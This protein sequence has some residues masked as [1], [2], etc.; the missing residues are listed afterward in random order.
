MSHPFRIAV[1]HSINIGVFGDIKEMSRDSFSV[2]NEVLQVG[3]Q[4]ADICIILG[5]M[6]NSTSPTSTSIASTLSILNSNITG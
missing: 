6:F 2:L 5:N 4:E 3:R 1:A